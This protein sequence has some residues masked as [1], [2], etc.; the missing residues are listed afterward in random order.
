MK[1][2]TKILILLIA[3]LCINQSSFAQSKPFSNGFIIKDVNGQTLSKPMI[4]NISSKTPDELGLGTAFLFEG[5]PSFA[6]VTNTLF[7]NK[8]TSGRYMVVGQSEEPLS[9]SLTFGYPSFENGPQIFDKITVTDGDYGFS[10][11]E[12]FAIPLTINPAAC[13]NIFIFQTFCSQNATYFTFKRDQIY[14]NSDLSYTKQLIIRMYSAGKV[15]KTLILPITVVGNSQEY[16]STG[17]GPIELYTILR[18][19]PGDKSTTF[20]EKSSKINSEVKMGLSESNSTE[21]KVTASVSVGI[22]AGPFNAGASVEGSSSTKNTAVN[23]SEET[24]NFEYTATDEITNANED[25]DFSDKFIAERRLYQY[26][27]GYSVNAISDGKQISVSA[28]SKLL[29]YPGRRIEQFYYTEKKLLS[30]LIPDLINSNKISEAKYWKDLIKMN[31]ELKKAAKR[32][33]PEVIRASANSSRKSI[34]YTKSSS[35]SISQ[36]ISIEKTK[37]LKIEVSGGFKL[38][39]VD[40]SA[41]VS[42]EKTW[43]FTSTAS[44]SNA[45]GTGTSTTTGYQIADN[46]FGDGDNFVINRWDDPVIGTPVWELQKE[47]VTSCPYEGGF[48]LDQPSITV[49]DPISKKEVKNA[50]YSDIQAGKEVVF[51]VSIKNLNTKNSRTYLMRYEPNGSRPNVTIPGG[52]NGVVPPFLLK[53]GETQKISIKISNSSDTPQPF[54][55]LKFILEPKCGGSDNNG[56]VADTITL[57]AFYGDTDLNRAPDN[58][59]IFNAFVLPIDGSLQTTYKNKFGTLSKFTNKNATTF[60]EEKTLVPP[61]NCQTGWCAETTDGK[62][63]ITNPVWFKFKVVSLAATISMCDKVNAGF[64]SQMTAFKATDINKPATFKRLAANDNGFCVGSD[65]SLLSLDKLT[66]GDTIYIMVDGFKGAQ[67]DFGISVK[68]LP[69]DGDIV[70]KQILLAV[71]GKINSVQS[72]SSSK[73]FSNI[74][75]TVEKNEQVF[76]PKSQDSFFGWKADSI[77]HTVWFQ[78]LAPPGGEVDIDVLNATFDSQV[79]VFEQGRTCDPDFFSQYPLIGANDDISISGGNDS[80]LSLKRLE[81]NKTYGI[82]I[83]GYKGAMGTFDI[84]LSIPIPANDSPC[85]AISLVTN[86]TGQGVFSNGGATSSTAEQAIA[87]PTVEL[88]Q[89]GGWSD[90]INDIIARRI[91]KSVWFKFKAP[92]EGAAQ[93]STCNQASFQLQLALYRTSNCND[94]SKYKLIAQDD[95][96]SLC[97]LPPSNDFP[98]GTNVRGS[99]LNLKGLEADST[100]YLLVDGGLNAEGQFSIDILTSPASPPPNDEACKAIALPTTG[101][102]QKGF[103]NLSASVSKTEYKIT[104]KEWIDRDMGGTVWFTFVAPASKEVEISTCGLANFDTQLAV[105]KVTDCKIDS[106]FVF[107]GA[108]EDGPKNCATD[109]DSF[110]PIKGLTAG[111]MYYLVVDGEGRSR[112]NFSI[113]IKDKITPGP[114]NDDVANAILLPVNG[115]IQ[116]GFTNIFATVQ[117]KEQNI[118]PKPA[119]N[120]DCTIGWC[121]NQVDNSVWFK[122]VAPADGKVNISTCDLADFDTQLALYSA[123][124]VADFTTFTLKGA[125]DAG[126]VDCSTFFDSFL[127]ITG[128]TAGQ[129]YYVLVDGFD[130]GNGTFNIQLSGSADTQ[131]PTSPTTLNSTSPP[132]STSAN[133]SWTAS[134]DNTGVKEYEIYVDGAL[135]GKTSETKF[136]IPNLKPSTTYTITVIAK[137]AAGNASAASAAIKI[138]TT[139]GVDTQ[140]PTSPTNLALTDTKSTTVS[141]S[142][143]AST[144]NIGVK[145]YEIYLDGKSVG[146]IA[147]TKFTISNLTPA[148]AYSITIIAKDAAGNASATSTSLKI[149]TA[150]AT[151]VDTQAPSS[152]TN[153]KTEIGITSIKI[154]WTAATDNIGIKEYRVFLD[155]T[156]KAS[157]TATTYDIIGLKSATAYSIYVTAVDAAGNVSLN[158]AVMKVT[159]LADIELSIGPE[160]TDTYLVYPNPFNDKV[161]IHIQNFDAKKGSIEIR[162]ASGK[163]ISIPDYKIEKN[164]TLSINT[165]NLSAGI[166][167]L[168]VKSNNKIY[169][170]KIVKF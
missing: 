123:T 28:K 6:E 10:S 111:Q 164:G 76:T 129:T 84:K 39:P 74:G 32:T 26:G 72:G 117:D 140:A 53:A 92:S 58:N 41:K 23:A 8:N 9:F 103:S 109:G 30:K 68:A 141:I 152:P 110:L 80:R 95:N 150:S 114:V 55:D 5:N 136:T 67:A 62:A 96:S 154:S 63:E 77:Q 167:T 16:L 66:L 31:D 113:F 20:I 166:M 100:Y 98:N 29:F 35:L 99:I 126:P 65:N 12:A 130:G 46:D 1:T 54:K 142:W 34:N 3:G 87:P 147:D 45:S 43:T 127:P 57:S 146:T 60:A 137:D 13:A 33:V 22:S 102:V 2:Y 135:V 83:D 131:A 119:G 78:F 90:K 155:G 128:L 73:I 15:S 52:L 149:T 116:K 124:N 27:I 56:Y 168:V 170:K 17:P 108:N 59:N 93:I 133:I 162:N 71:D 112:G 36:E 40:A 47:S 145:E 165:D 143:I 91:E 64:N 121:D 134:T 50:K 107:V 21:S 82:L 105:Y 4:I 151:V 101:V 115:A 25:G 163:V 153:L 104:P 139:A 19:L 37:N 158:S 18:A 106:N 97:R 14:K 148:T 48:Q 89:P 118:R 75:A 144:D 156:L 125:N 160:K 161:N 79:A 94:F 44:N 169:V 61:V 159:T 69:P 49:I 138:T 81:K 122:F 132:L 11:G 42:T 7:F 38:G 70:C 24:Y 120:Q 51:D 85:N 88:N 86:A 157:P